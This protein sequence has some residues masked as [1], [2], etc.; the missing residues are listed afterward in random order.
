MIKKKK[1]KKTELFLS[2]SFGP[3]DILQTNWLI[4]K[5]IVRL[6]ND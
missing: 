3:V 5:I 6:N 4:E 2:L 1:K